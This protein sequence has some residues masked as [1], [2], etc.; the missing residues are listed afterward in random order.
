MIIILSIL[1]YFLLLLGL[2]W[3]TSRKADNR[4]FFSARHSSPWAMV[5]FG[6]IGASISGVTFVSVPGMVL[7]V[8]MTYLQMCM[9]YILG[10]FAVA[11]VLLPVYYRL[12]LTSIYTYLQG[13]LG[14]R[15]YTTGASFFLIGV[16][17]STP[18][19]CRL[20]LPFRCSSF[21]SGSTPD[22]AASARS[23]G[24]TRSK[25]FASWPRWC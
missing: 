25:R 7:S 6:M 21:S 20:L 15:S 11:F 18:I 23:C 4:D 3:L 8:Q 22:G 2:S 19:M 10:Y 5:A 12:R 13:R 24:L 17:S 9:G 14:A 16:L 1:V